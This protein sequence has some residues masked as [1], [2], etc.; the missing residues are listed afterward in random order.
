M[1][2]RIELI[3]KN[4]PRAGFEP[5]IL[6]LLVIRLTNLAIKANIREILYFAVHDARTTFKG[7]GSGSGFE[8]QNYVSLL[9]ERC[10]KARTNILYETA[11]TTFSNV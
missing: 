10:N 2:S 9:L 4:M 5:T 7:K 11:K 1:E 8:L 3:A 6:S